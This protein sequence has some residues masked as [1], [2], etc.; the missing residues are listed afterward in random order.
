MKFDLFSW[1]LHS[2]VQ[3]IDT[4]FYKFKF[5]LDVEYCVYYKTIRIPKRCINYLDLQEA[6]SAWENLFY[7]TYH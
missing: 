1:K 4:F 2:I 5:A 7:L 3:N 6:F